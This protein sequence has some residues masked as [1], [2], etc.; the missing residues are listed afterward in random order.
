MPRPTQEQ[1]AKI[2]Q[3]VLG[4]MDEESIYVF[5]DMMIDSLEVESHDMYIHEN[6][7]AT[8]MGDALK[9]VSLLLNHAANKSPVGRSFNASLERTYSEE[10]DSFVTSL[11]GDFYID[12]GRNTEFGM[13]TDDICKAVDSGVLNY[14]SIGFSADKWD[15]SICGNDIR[16]FRECSH[17]PGLEYIIENEDG[18]SEVAVCKIIVGSDGRGRLLENSLVYA[19]AC[20]RASIIRNLS[21]GAVTEYSNSPRLHL[22]DDIKNVPSDVPIYQYFTQDGLVWFTDISERTEGAE[23]LRQR[24]EGIVSGTVKD[25]VVEKLDSKQEFVEDTVEVENKVVELDTVSEELVTVFE[26]TTELVA[27]GELESFKEELKLLREEVRLLK[28]ENEA[29]KRQE[30]V[31]DL[32]ANDLMAKA[33]ELSV[34]LYGNDFKVGLYEKF[35]ASLSLTELKEVV[36]GL[37]EDVKNKFAGTRVSSSGS[38]KEKVLL[39]DDFETEEEFRAYVAEEATKHAAE[40]GVSLSEATKLMYKKF[41]G[42]GSGK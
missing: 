16:D 42:D 20:R 18:V 29:L 19:G 11:K 17:Y 34:R 15:C 39:R 31:I 40:N 35:L 28:E 36:G 22:V 5:S 3:F 8:F 12:L 37:E 23:F 2:S 33:I 6:L 4:E 1:L 9:G 41:I 32:F 7:L 27:G 25:N 26:C 21:E 30:E 10:T 14:S 38:R 24:G 13:T